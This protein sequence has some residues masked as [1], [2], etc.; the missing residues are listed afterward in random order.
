VFFS[1]FFS[2]PIFT[3]HNLFFSFFVETS[4]SFL[5]NRCCYLTDIKKE[6][7]T[8]N[9]SNGYFKRVSNN[10]LHIYFFVVEIFMGMTK[11]MHFNKPELKSN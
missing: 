10:A 4:I 1:L 5:L 7:I 3:L 2:S 8:K 6:K 11:I 9:K